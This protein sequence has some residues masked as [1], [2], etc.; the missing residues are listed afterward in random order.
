MTIYLEDNE[1]D[2]AL[3]SETWFKKDMTFNIHNILTRNRRN[4]Y[5]GVAI[6]VNQTF[7]A[8]K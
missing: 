2:L 1:F 6:L 8:N 3:S 4:G 5:G 7:K